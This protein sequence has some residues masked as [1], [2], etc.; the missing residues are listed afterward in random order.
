MSAEQLTELRGHGGVVEG[1]L[2][3]AH[4][5]RLPHALCLEGP[6]GV[7]KFLAA[8][9]LA[10]GLLCTGE[11]T[12]ERA[13]EHTGEHTGDAL[14]A[15][16]LCGPCK[17]FLAGTHPDVLVLD[18]RAAGEES[19]KLNRIAERDDSPGPTVGGFLTLKAGE[20]GYRVVIVRDAELMNAAAQNALLKTLEEP[21][22]RVVLALVTSRPRQLLET[23]RSRC[24]ALSCAPLAQDE[25]EAILGD[26]AAGGERR[27][28]LM[29]WGRGAPGRVLELVARDMLTVRGHLAALLAGEAEPAESGRC[30]RELEGD[31]GGKTATAQARERLRA[32]LEVG[33]EL[34]R[35]LLLAGGHG[36]VHGAALA[37]VRPASQ[38]LRHWQV[39]QLLL[40]LQ[41]VGAN[42]NTD[43]ILDRALTALHR[44]ELDAGCL[45]APGSGGWAARD[46]A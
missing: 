24:V 2:R 40:A 32:V 37:A 44:R 35:E 10:A 22:A 36:T 15:C 39:D 17:R 38:R 1:L 8:R 19:L 18:P 29:S 16:G 41:D 31:F 33:L 21:A 43:A 30:L 46:G 27:A 14:R 34:L 13:G 4:E 7:G 12:G 5:G 6:E 25:M 28:E 20:G 42:M 26:L 3:A 9:H 23:V 45:T 11:R